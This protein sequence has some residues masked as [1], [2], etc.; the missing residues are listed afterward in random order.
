M[1]RSS[2]EESPVRTRPP[3]AEAVAVEELSTADVEVLGRLPW[4]SNATFLADLRR[5]DGSLGLQAVYKPLRG[6]RPLLDFPPGLYRREVAAYLLSSHLGWDLVPPTVER[7]GPL[8]HG[9]LQLFVP[10]DFEQHYFTLRG[11]EDHIPLLMRLCAFDVAANAADRKGGHVLVEGGRIW[12]VDNG[13]CFHS[14]FKLRTVIWDFAGQPL[15][16]DV[17]AGLSLLRGEGAAEVLSPLLT[18]DE[19]DA[20]LERA[21][22]LLALGCF[23]HPHS[24]RAVPWPP[25]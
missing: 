12:A 9:S 18:E 7:D 2:K 3:V 19:V 6:E 1:G 16:E 15:P 13:L 11:R 22:A 14:D 20:L 5:A 25:V 8:G 24:T 17:I 10:A 21:D 4:S 23:P